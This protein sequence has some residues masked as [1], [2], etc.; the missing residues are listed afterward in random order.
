MRIWMD[1]PD[2]RNRHTR[3][4]VRSKSHPHTSDATTARP[5]EERTRLHP[6]TADTY[7]T[8]RAIHTTHGD[9]GTS[10]LRTAGEVA[11]EGQY[12]LARILLIWAAAAVPMA[13]LAWVAAP[14]VGDRL[15]LERVMDF[16][17]Q[18]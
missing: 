4:R 7:D 10:T 1:V 12:S 18:G 13:V 17:P 5:T 6:Y 11:G 2:P 14:A 15:D 3:R 16:A 9:P 8:Y